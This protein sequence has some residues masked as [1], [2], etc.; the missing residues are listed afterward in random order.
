MKFKTKIKVHNTAAN[1]WRALSE[2]EFVQ[3][4]MFGSSVESDW[5]VGSKVL[6]YMVKDGVRT[7]IVSGTVEETEKNKTLVHSL[8][9]VGASYPATEENHIHVR[10]T[11]TPTENETACILEIEQF[12]FEDATE[13]EKRYNSSKNGWEHVLPLLRDVAEAIQ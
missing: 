10:Y 7:D 5:N 2:S 9:P 1:V 12:G 8:F 11:L 4:Y 13:G 6:Y 3:Q